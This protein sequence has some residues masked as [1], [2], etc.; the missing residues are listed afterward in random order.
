MT[1]TQVVAAVGTIVQTNAQKIHTIIQSVNGGWEGWLQ[2]ETALALNALGGNGTQWQRER[3]YPGVNNNRCDVWVQPG[4]SQDI[5]IW[6]ELKTQNSVTNANDNV[7]GRYLADMQKLDNSTIPTTDVRLAIA[8]YYHLG[9]G[10]VTTVNGWRQ[11]LGTKFTIYQSNGNAFAA[12]QNNI[13]N[14]A[15]TLAVYKLI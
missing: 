8:Y 9:Q 13:A 6:V 7:L 1:G 15:H 11:Q 5:K 12:V 3:A 14:D 2:V 4:N 10:D